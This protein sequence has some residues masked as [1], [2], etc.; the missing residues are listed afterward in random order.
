MT[1]DRESTTPL[2]GAS[3]HVVGEKHCADN[4]R[5]RGDLKKTIEDAVA[6]ML[7]DSLNMP[8]EALVKALKRYRKQVGIRALHRR[9]ACL[10]LK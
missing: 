2:P 7:D 9:I 3:F 8:N 4:F 10:T 5:L 6:A 1:Y